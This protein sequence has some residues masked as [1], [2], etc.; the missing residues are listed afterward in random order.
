M[1][2]EA[3]LNSFHGRRTAWESG[4]GPRVPVL[5]TPF[6]FFHGRERSFG[7][8]AGPAEGHAPLRGQSEAEARRVGESPGSQASALTPRLGWGLR[9]GLGRLTRRPRPQT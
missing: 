2:T 6:F 3:T 8:Q 9:G 5:C 4:R 7:K 1:Q